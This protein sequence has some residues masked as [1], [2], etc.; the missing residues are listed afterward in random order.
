[1]LDQFRDYV[2]NPAETKLATGYIAHYDQATQ[3]Y[4][5]KSSDYDQ[6]IAGIPRASGDPGEMSVLPIGTE[7]QV[8]TLKGFSTITGVIRRP[9]VSNQAPVLLPTTTVDGTGTNPAGSVSGAGVAYGQDGDP[10][11]LLQGDWL[12]RG[13]EGNYV[14]V[15]S[16]GFNGVVAS[17]QA[18]VYTHTT[19]VDGVLIRARQYAVSTAMSEMLVSSDANG[20][21]TLTYNATDN[22]NDAAAGKWTIR[23]SVGAGGE[24]IDLRTTTPE[25]NILAQIKVSAAGRISLIG[26]AGVDLISG[27]GGTSVEQ[28]EG[29][30]TV[31]VGRDYS[32]IAGGKVSTTADQVITDVVGSV[33]LSANG[34]H[35]QTVGAD[36]S[37]LVMG[38]SKTVVQGGTIPPV[39]GTVVFK[40]DVVNGASELVMADPFRTTS[41]GQSYS[42]IQYGQAANVNF[43]LQPTAVGSSFN[44]VSALPNTVNLGCDGAATP[45]PVAGGHTVT[46]TPA[47]FGVMKF[48]P[49]ASMMETLIN[50][51]DAHAHLT[52]VGPTGPALA[53][54]IGPVRA[55]VMPLLLPIRSVRVSVGL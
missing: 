13:P 28:T 49:W 7:V 55:V 6:P 51:L 34:N 19:P 8:T 31:Q 10:T 9:S 32:V 15:F 24:G 39:P 2:F 36:A 29:G 43:V 52:A 35:I 54:P 18:A 26:T 16:G 27:D 25:G 45:N 12:R 23:L 30:K 53:G 1:M 17:P 48:E 42:V 44:V 4:I 21:A 38:S 5:V 47:A 22:A 41:I 50:W 46:A 33:S 11:D 3:T 14:G 37:A 40:R 20:K